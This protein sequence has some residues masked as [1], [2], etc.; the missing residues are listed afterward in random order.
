M[1]HI[2]RTEVSVACFPVFLFP[3]ETE[4]FAVGYARMALVDVRLAVGQVVERLRHAEVLA[5]HTLLLL[6]IVQTSWT[7]CSTSAKVRVVVDM[8]I[9]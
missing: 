1:V 2:P 4:S 8:C 7:L 9:L 6:G 5:S 3:G